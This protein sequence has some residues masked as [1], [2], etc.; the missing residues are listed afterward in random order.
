MTGISGSVREQ[1]SFEK[2]VGIFEG[3]VD[4]AGGW[5]RQVGELP[6]HPDGLQTGI[7]FE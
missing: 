6:L 2:M 7:R 5:P 4:M 3:E 1:K